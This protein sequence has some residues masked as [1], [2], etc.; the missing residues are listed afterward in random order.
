MSVEDG[1]KDVA[2]EE[3]PLHSYAM[4]FDVGWNQIKRGGERRHVVLDGPPPPGGA[5][6]GPMLATLVDPLEAHRNAL[7]VALDDD[8][9]V[10]PYISVRPGVA[11]ANRV[12]VAPGVGY[13]ATPTAESPFACSIVGTGSVYQRVL[14]Q[15]G[16]HKG[17]TAS[18]RGC[19]VPIGWLSAYKVVLLQM[20]KAVRGE[21]A[22]E[23]G[24]DSWDPAEPSVDNRARV[25][26]C[27][28]SALQNGSSVYS[29]FM[30]DGGGLLALETLQLCNMCALFAAFSR[31]K[32]LGC[33]FRCSG[34]RTQ[35]AKEFYRVCRGSRGF[36]AALPPDS[37]YHGGLS[38]GWPG[39][40]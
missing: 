31:S 22:K 21:L 37:A 18:Q 40:A 26:R 5:T 6:A 36:R 12:V 27:V 3:I 19:V 10:L 39:A 29:R 30:N 24:V 14:A 7:L 17:G 35:E 20:N 28:Q 15:C 11:T 32:E 4:S 13:V 2:T 23:Q 8:V 34:G 38:S 25:G 33:W 1:C 9:E 16:M